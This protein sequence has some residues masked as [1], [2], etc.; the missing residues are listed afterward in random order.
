MKD[1]E[2]NQRGSESISEHIHCCTVLRKSRIAMLLVESIADC[3]RSTNNINATRRVRMTTNRY[4]I[5]LYGQM[6]VTAIDGS[7]RLGR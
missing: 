1:T 4:W 6:H 7:H 3:S 5:I 2:V